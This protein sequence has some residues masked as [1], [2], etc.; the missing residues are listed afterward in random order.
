MT[1]APLP[2]S[3]TSAAP[4]SSTTTGA[5]TADNPPRLKMPS[6]FETYQYDSV[7]QY[8]DK[9]IDMVPE[10]AKVNGTYLDEFSVRS[11]NVALQFG[12]AAVDA[13]RNA[14][15]TKAAFIPAVAFMPV[16][17]NEFCWG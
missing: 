17:C 2:T 14:M 9:G 8:Y 11:V 5:A 7:G 1:A 10:A 15:T 16:S 12:W 3:T 4:E 13:I 6:K